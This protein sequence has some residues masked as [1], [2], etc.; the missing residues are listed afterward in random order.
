MFRIPGRVCTSTLNMRGV[1]AEGQG[2][3][4]VAPGPFS[5]HFQ[6]VP[7]ISCGSYS[8][9]KSDWET[10]NFWNFT[11]EPQTSGINFLVIINFH[12]F[13]PLLSGYAVITVIVP[14]SQV[15]TTF[16]GYPCRLKRI[17]SSITFNIFQEKP[18]FSKTILGYLWG[19][20]FDLLLFYFRPPPV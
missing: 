12:Y 10:E 17:F 1:R 4:V 15:K 20:P 9:L 19:R 16:I 6:S 8:Q 14:L 3:R 7:V 18:T 2:R 11:W 13:N 5:N